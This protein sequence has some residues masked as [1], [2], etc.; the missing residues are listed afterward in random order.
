LTTRQTNYDVIYVLKA[1][2]NE[3]QQSPLSR[4]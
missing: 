2:I 3:R 4:L 1:M